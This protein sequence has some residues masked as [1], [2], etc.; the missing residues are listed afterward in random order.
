MT[1]E[2]YARRGPYPTQG[3]VVISSYYSKTHQTSLRRDLTC[4]WTSLSLRLG[5]FK[6][7]LKGLSAL[8]NHAAYSPS[9][10]SPR[11]LEPTRVTVSAALKAHC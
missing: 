5:G 6:M 3:I 9:A 10:E 1:L 2:V 8:S 4:C 7:S 11:I